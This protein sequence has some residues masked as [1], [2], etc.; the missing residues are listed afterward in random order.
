MMKPQGKTLELPCDS[1][2]PLLGIHSEELKARSGRDIRIPSVHSSIIHD[3][4]E[5]G[6]ALESTDRCIGKRNVV[7]T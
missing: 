2:S 5:A 7:R 4:Q 3:G 1:A 6:A